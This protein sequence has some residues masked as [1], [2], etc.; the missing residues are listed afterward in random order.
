MLS[1]DAQYLIDTMAFPDLLYL[2]VYIP[3]CSSVSLVDS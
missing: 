1:H 3:V 2:S